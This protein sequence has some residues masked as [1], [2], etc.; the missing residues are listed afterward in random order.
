MHCPRAALALL[1]DHLWQQGSSI[2]VFP[3]GLAL[4]SC[5]TGSTRRASRLERLFGG[6]HNCFYCTS[7]F[8][9]RSRTQRHL[10]EGFCISSLLLPF[11]ASRQKC[12]TT[13]GRV[14]K[15]K[16]R[17]ERG[18]VYMNSFP[19]PLTAHLVGIMSNLCSIPHFRL[20]SG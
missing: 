6:K 12:L 7:A 13:E 8:L 16:E 15:S 11:C 20:S 3:A 10:V 9:F 14:R 2:C 18:E 19:Q 5:A 17:P 1:K 4:G